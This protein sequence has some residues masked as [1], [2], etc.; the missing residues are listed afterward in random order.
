MA[1]ATEVLSGFGSAGES[2]GSP[3]TIEVT[4]VSKAFPGIRA[5]RRVTMRVAGGEVHGLV[6]ENGAGKST[7]AKIVSGAQT[8]DR[9]RVEISGVDMTSA[10]PRER[11]AAGV[12]MVYQDPNVVPELS[13]AAY[14]FLSRPVAH[15]PF[16]ALRERTKKFMS[17]AREL[18]IDIDPGERVGSMSVAKQR[19][20]DVMVAIISDCRV[21]I[22]DEPTASLGPSEREKLFK[23]MA[24]LRARKVTI[25]Y[26]SH[27]LDEVLALCDRVSVMRDGELLATRPSQEW[28]AS[29]LVEA[30]LG[31]KVIATLRRHESQESDIVL[32]VEDVTVPG[33][34]R[35]VSL[36]LRAGE[37]LGV[38]GLLGSGRS[39]LLRAIAGAEP[40]AHGRMVV[41][42]APVRWPHSVRDALERGI[43]LSPEDRKREGLVLSMS[44]ALNVALTNLGAISKV[45]IVQRR[46]L[47]RRTSE[48]LGRLGF[49]VQQVNAL[50]GTLSGGNQQ[51]LVVAKCMN[52]D[53]TV[54]LMDEPTAGIDIG[55]KADVFE[56]M[57]R[58][59]E[60][61]KG[62]VF[63]SSEIEEV[64]GISNRVLVL[65][66]GRA[67]GVLEGDELTEARVLQLAFALGSDGSSSVG[68]S[69][70]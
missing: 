24:R 14:A 52:R 67:M 41:E 2:Q 50:A 10:G 4:G 60:R 36:S 21:L 68:G 31:R 45:Q 42:G 57:V 46:A 7:L 20:L 27:N 19:L 11:S 69:K 37:I 61:G 55:A 30:M 15:G 53:P 3:A 39:T 49:K 34:L 17:I 64:L 8:P 48:L 51:K 28:N 44:G 23:T 66:R 29:E 63:T 13:A 25:L 9:G 5:L 18:E 32:A 35:D 58:L 16:L 6:G 40:S 54:L 70:E 65:A 43:V 1:A 59:A 22:M 26:I 33:A 38:A 62:I 47:H 12:G 56:A